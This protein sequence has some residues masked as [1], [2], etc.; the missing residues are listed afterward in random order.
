M[1][2]FF[3]PASYYPH[4]P[5][6]SKTLANPALPFLQKTVYLGANKLLGL[7]KLNRAV[8]NVKLQAGADRRLPSQELTAVG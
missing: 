1:K 4:P 7:L 3:L 5:L 8:G 6:V 2:S